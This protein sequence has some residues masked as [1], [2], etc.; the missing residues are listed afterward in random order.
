MAVTEVF[1]D[2]NNLNEAPNGLQR[3]VGTIAGPASYAAGGF[4]ADIETD[5]EMD[6]APD[7]VFVQASNGLPC[8]YDS[9]NA[10]IQ[11]YGA[12]A[13]NAATEIADTT[14]LSGVTFTMLALWKRD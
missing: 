4:A 2:S 10:K 5:L 14:N 11:V 13:S 3:A 7:A 8:S 6:G 9:N 12:V 1:S